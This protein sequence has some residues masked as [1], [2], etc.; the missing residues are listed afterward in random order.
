MGAHGTLEDALRNVAEFHSSKSDVSARGSGAGKHKSGKKDKSKSDKHS[1]SKKQKK[2][3]KKHARS[4]RS[5]SESP[6]AESLEEQLARGRQAVRSTREF[7]SKHPDVKQDFREVLPFTFG[8]AHRAV[9]QLH[10][11]LQEWQ[12][13]CRRHFPLLDM[14]LPKLPLRLLLL[15]LER[16]DFHDYLTKRMVERLQT[17]F[18]SLLEASQAA[19]ESNPL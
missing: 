15:L 2:A 19:H 18:C 6:E 17:R 11:Q 14:L 5:S 13:L 10:W 1:K 4:D 8:C 16:L 12:Y 7:L 9:S 3:K